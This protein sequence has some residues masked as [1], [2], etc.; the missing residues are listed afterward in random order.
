MKDIKKILNTSN[1]NLST[2]VSTLAEIGKNT[3]VPFSNMKCIG[4]FKQPQTKEN[5][6][7]E[8]NSNQNTTSTKSKKDA[9]K[10]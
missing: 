2:V 8:E 6:Q 5:S 4:F 3:E 1:K 9:D 10:K 7:E